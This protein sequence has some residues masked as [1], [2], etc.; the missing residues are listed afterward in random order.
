ME[1]KTEKTKS[2]E[3]E[4]TVEVPYER[5]VKILDKA[6]K[7]YARNSTL[8][9]FR[10]GKV[11]MSIIKNRYGE[12][13]TMETAEEA[14]N[15]FYREA[16]NKQEYSPLA[17]GEIKELDYGE[18]KPFTFKAVFQIMPEVKIE[19]Y[20]ELITHLENIEIEEDE[21]EAGLE[22]LRDDDAA[23][24]PAEE[25]KGDHHVVTFDLQFLDK[26][27]V[28]IL[29][30]KWKDAEIEI[31]RKTMGDKFDEAL[32]GKKTGDEF[33]YVNVNEAFEEEEK[34]EEYMMITVKDIKLKELPELNDEFAQSISKNIHTIEDLRKGL[35]TH[36]SNQAASRA[37][38]QM[39]TRLVDILI[40]NNRVD[41]PPVMLDDYLN[42]L[43][44][45][46]R[47]DNPNLKED[48]FRENNRQSALWN[49]KWFLIRKA[50][51]TQENLQADDAEIEAEFEKIITATP[52]D[53]AVIRKYYSEERNRNRI[54]DDIEERKALEFIE[55]KA[56]ITQKNMT[57]KEF[58][59]TGG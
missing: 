34:R 50:M 6:F 9:G 14:V 54:K 46:A 23:L 39:F 29:T 21:I 35:K 42:R 17:P 49:L 47:K 48:D 8:K 36:I 51:I 45:S 38:S 22:Q 12:A 30:H 55:S 58:I 11:P 27:G 53:P 40:E 33:K 20:D 2:Y 26:T 19:G 16:L 56:K 44:E 10:P 15:D 59:K 24:I 4:L 1:V 18:N 37:K 31:G 43:M 13:I 52:G 28:P 57:Y 25:V 5:W 32:M 7:D 41:I 3:V